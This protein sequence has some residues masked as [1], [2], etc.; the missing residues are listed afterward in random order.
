MAAL[1]V[2]N[3]FLLLDFLSVKKVKYLRCRLICFQDYD[4]FSISLFVINRDNLIFIDNV[5][6]FKD[7]KL[8]DFP[9]DIT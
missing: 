3:N 6:Y 1:I 4:S 8:I 7:N 9:S 5:V 2:G